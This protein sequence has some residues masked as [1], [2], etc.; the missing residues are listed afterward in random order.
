[1]P[2]TKREFSGFPSEDYVWAS[3]LSQVFEDLPQLGIQ[4]AAAHAT[5]WKS[6]VTNASIALTVLSLITKGLKKVR[7]GARRSKPPQ[8][9]NPTATFARQF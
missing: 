9:S 8:T 7:A 4:I 2:W 3:C 1:M 5:E 6:T